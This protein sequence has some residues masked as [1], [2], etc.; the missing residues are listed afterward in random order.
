MSMTH[1]PINPIVLVDDEEPMLRSLTA[2]LLSHGL[3]NTR[4]VSDSRQGL[5]KYLKTK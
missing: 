3:T 1:Y 2:V 5:N 4:A